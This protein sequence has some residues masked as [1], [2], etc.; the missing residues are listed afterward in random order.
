[1]SRPRTCLCCR[2]KASLNEHAL[3]P[4]CAVCLHCEKRPSVHPLG[5][6]QRCHATPGIRLLYV[7]R[8]GWTTE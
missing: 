3:C 2:R 5:L 8:R 1:M 4:E 7:R 6:C